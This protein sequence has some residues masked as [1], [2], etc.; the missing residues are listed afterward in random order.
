[1]HYW[2]STWWR[3]W[4]VWNQSKWGHKFG[5]WFYRT[6]SLR[7]LMFEC[8]ID[9]LY[10]CDEFI[11]QREQVFINFFKKCMASPSNVEGIISVL[12]GL[13]CG[14]H[15]IYSQ[16]VSVTSGSLEKRHRA[17]KVMIVK[18]E[19]SRIG[20]VEEYRQ[21]FSRLSCITWW[22]SGREVRFFWGGPIVETVPSP[23]IP[24]WLHVDN[25][26]P[27]LKYGNGYSTFTTELYC[28]SVFFKLVN[29]SGVV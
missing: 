23:F 18:L 6:I 11:L 8:T 2:A 12:F 24:P 17:G 16:H 14:Y 26:L 1:M 4:D 28:Q 7:K 5:I 25:F 21:K 19:T 27:N 22:R 29:I 20:L 3:R 9:Q 15:N 10:N 13:A